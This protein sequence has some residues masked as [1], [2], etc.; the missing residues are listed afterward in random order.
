[1]NY[2]ALKKLHS[3]SGVI[4]IAGFV[5]FHLFENHHSV[6]GQE[7]F[8][9][10]V[11]FIRSM[12]L[13][14]L[15]EIGLLA[16]IVFHAGLG[17]YLAKTAKHNVGTLPNRANWMYLLQRLSGFILLFFIAYHVYTTRFANVPTDQMFQ[18]MAEQVSNPLIFG[19]YILGVVSASLHL[20]NGLWGF[21]V[22]WGIVGGQKSQD[23]VWKVC[24][25]LALGVCLM[26]INA[27]LGFRGQAVTLFE[28]V[29]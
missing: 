25:G 8:N 28:H 23:M 22:A 29:H 13:L 7:A 12:P 20:G 16:P 24:M 17:I 3:L 27:L 2:F 15:L 11:A 4:P 10:T 14:Y 19:G 1:M 5:V 26:G 18:Y 21:L 9:D 6:H